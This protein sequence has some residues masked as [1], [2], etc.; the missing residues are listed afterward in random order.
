MVTEGPPTQRHRVAPVLVLLP[1]SEGKTA[2]R[3]GVPLDL[4]RLALADQL[5]GPRTAV[6]EALV[7]LC[8]TDPGKA[9]D[10]LALGPTQ[11]DEIERNQL[12]LEAPTAIAAKVYTGVLY[13]ALDSATITG[14]ARRRLNSWVLVQSALFGLVGMADRIPAYRLAGDT[15]LPGLGGVARHWRDTLSA[16]IPDRAGRGLVV[17]LRSTTYTAF[18]RGDARTV[19][20]RVLQDTGGRRKVVSHFNK[21]TKG[22]ILRALVEDGSTPSTADELA[23]HLAGLGWHTETVSP[24]QVDVV[25]R[26]L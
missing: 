10:V 11:V 18:W 12:L 26:E 6:M 7:E 23:E 9:A 17:D 21:A 24:R 25:V 22:R 4:D 15:T 16:V 20:V 8:T 1:P 2:P 19:S 13:A 14:T 5:R 3:R